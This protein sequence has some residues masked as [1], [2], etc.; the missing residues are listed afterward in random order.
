[1]FDYPKEYI[2]DINN[3]P[4][5]PPSRQF[6]EWFFCETETKESIEQTEKWSEYIKQYG[7]ELKNKQNVPNL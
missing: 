5:F 1:M 6:R 2:V 7:I 3:P 4:I